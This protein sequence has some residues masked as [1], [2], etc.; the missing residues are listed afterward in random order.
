MYYLVWGLFYYFEKI[1]K[2]RSGAYGLRV[3]ISMSD[4]RLYIGVREQNGELLKPNYN[5]HILSVISAAVWAQL[6]LTLTRTY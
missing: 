5:L 4:I 2:R 3:S 6:E 1:S